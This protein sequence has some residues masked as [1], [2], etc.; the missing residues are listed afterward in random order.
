MPNDGV[1][2]CVG[3]KWAGFGSSGITTPPPFG[4]P[5]KYCAPRTD[6][7]AAKQSFTA[8]LKIRSEALVSSKAAS[9]QEIEESV[10]AVLRE[11]R[12]RVGA[13]EGSQE[14]YFDKWFDFGLRNLDNNST[15]GN[16]VMKCMG[17]TVGEVLKFDGLF[18]AKERLD[19]F[20]ALVKS[21][22]DTL[23]DGE[24]DPLL[25][26][27]KQEPHKTSKA[28]SGRWR[29]IQAC[30]LVDTMIDRILYAQ[31]FQLF[32][33]N[34]SVVM[35]GWTPLGGGHRLVSTR[36]RGNCLMADRTAFD[37]TV[38]KDDVE[39]LTLLY[40]EFHPLAPEWWVLR[41]RARFAL[42]YRNCQF[43]FQDGSI[44]H[45]D[46]WGVQKSGC[47]LTFLSNSLIQ[48]LN[49]AMVCNRLGLACDDWPLVLGDD[50]VQEP[51]GRDYLD[52]LAAVGR[53]VRSH[54]SPIPEFAGFTYEPR[55]MPV[56]LD[57]H[58]F[59]LMHMSDEFLVETLVSYSVLY[60]NTPW[61]RWFLEEISKRD[62]S[63][64]LTSRQALSLMDG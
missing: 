51:R 29:L 3:V 37:W 47:Y 21:R 59:R 6:S 58:A 22:W 23:L 15:V 17:S 10:D 56:Y 49:H 33:D 1:G 42:I 44:Y 43:G 32:I 54:V 41:H 14:D 9:G 8:H 13:F 46:F 60:V 38:T 36:F 7:C 55:P 18:Y 27:I 35:A 53:L 40:E 5:S 62:P 30:S 24:A 11:I 2:P 34:S 64:L 4:D 19:Y 20:R 50:T 57:K 45:Q 48:L 39:A 61:F 26:F 12:F 25:V 52:G 63:A 16:C 31:L 28:Q